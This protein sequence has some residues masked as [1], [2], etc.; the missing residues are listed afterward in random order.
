MDHIQEFDGALSTPHTLRELIH[1]L[2]ALCSRNHGKKV[3]IGDVIQTLGVRSFAPIIV[4]VGLIAITPIDSIPTLP[5]TFG[6]GIFLTAGQML[7]GR[8]SLWLPS[9]VARRSVKA[10]RLQKALFWL[11]PYAEKAEGWLG[12]RLTALT[13][14][15]F[16]IAIALCC[17][18]LAALMPIL[19]LLPLVSTVPPLPSQL[20]ASPYLCTTDWPPFSDLLLLQSRLA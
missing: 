17:A 4:A 15:P 2:E 20:S 7:I 19:E 18:L 1:T 11:E 13:Q 12:M 14:G 16:L 5:T 9:F 8:R 3:S 10:D 6:I